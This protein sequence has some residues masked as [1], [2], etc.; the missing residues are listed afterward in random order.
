MGLL[1][2]LLRSIVFVN[3]AILAADYTQLNSL[4]HRFRLIVPLGY[5][6]LFSTALLPVILACEITVWF[7]MKKAA[8][9]ASHQSRGAGQ[10]WIDVFVALLWVIAAFFLGARG[11]ASWMS[12]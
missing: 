7:L 6:V 10:I 11:I 2:F 4:L 3:L 8:P 9:S 12:I 5:W 1:Q